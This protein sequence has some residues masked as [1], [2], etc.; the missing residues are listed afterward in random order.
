MNWLNTIC[1]CVFGTFTFFNQEMI[2][3]ASED[4]LSGRQLPT[5]TVL[6]CY[7][8]PL[9][10]TKIVA[11]WFVQKLPYVAK[12]SFITLCMVLGLSLITFVMDIKVKLTGIALNAIAA[13][14]SEVIFLGLTSFYPQ[15]CIS[16]FV[17]GT[18]LSSLISPL[19]FTGITTWTCVSPK[20]AIMIT[21]PLPLLLLVFY[22]LL[23]KDYIT[24]R[25]KE[26]IEVEYAI[27]PSASDTME[28]T[29]TDREESLCSEQLRIGVK[30]LPYIIPLLLS[31]GAEYLSNSSVITTIAFPNS[32]FLP[33]DHFLYY[34]FSYEMGKFLGRSHLFIL[35]CLPSDIIELLKCK[36]TWV[37]AVIEV[38]H[39]IFFVFESWYHFVSYI[40]IIIALCFTLGLVAGMIVLNSPHAVVSQV[41]P[42]EK[43][44]ALGLLTVGNGVGSFVAGLV[45]LVVE[46]YL[47]GKCVEHFSASKEFCFT[48]P[49]NMTGWGSNIHC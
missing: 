21:I 17:A 48:R 44:F 3:I 22:A 8:T 38:A 27:V 29:T 45:G 42:E 24:N 39:L 11:P 31:F 25:S 32:K 30:I 18:G 41:A 20:T 7:V 15:I 49:Q 9:M 1:F 5:A 28:Q 13:G 26:R 12:A 14:A 10:I 19:Y 37:F 4:I 35:S 46:P 2:L 16:A 34:F 36:R 33:R 40:W 43:E 47:T 6:V 23:D